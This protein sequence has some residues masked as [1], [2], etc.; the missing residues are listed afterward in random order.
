ML[1]LGA[2]TKSTIPDA[3]FVKPWQITRIAPRRAPLTEISA[4]E[5][6]VTSLRQRLNPR[7]EP[8]FNRLRV[9]KKPTHM[10]SV[11]Q[12]NNVRGSSEAFV[13]QLQARFLLLCKICI[14][15]TP[16]M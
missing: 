7:Q 6:T 11:K 12:T 15:T 8:T 2:V 10:I 16:R 14:E 9:F 13:S 3:N 5:K 1:G 4:K